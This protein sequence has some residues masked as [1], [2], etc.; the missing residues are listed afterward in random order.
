MCLAK[1]CQRAASAASRMSLDVRDVTSSALSKVVDGAS[2]LAVT[3]SENRM[4]SD[5]EAEA[6]W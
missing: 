3:S 2:I 5:N 6:P 1:G 4:L